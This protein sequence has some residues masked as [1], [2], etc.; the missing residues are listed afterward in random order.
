MRGT[1]TLNLNGGNKMQISKETNHEYD[2][3]NQAWL[4]NGKYVSC[5]HPESMNCQCFGKLHEG[6]TKDM[7]FI[8]FH[9]PED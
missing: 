3:H 5:N 1:Y 8:G 2:Y 9:C 6:E 7:H 4:V